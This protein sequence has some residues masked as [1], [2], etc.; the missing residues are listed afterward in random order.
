MYIYKYSLIKNKFFQIYKLKKHLYIIMGCAV[1]PLIKLGEAHILW[2]RE[3]CVCQTAKRRVC[4][5]RESKS[6]VL[7]LR[8]FS[9]VQRN[10]QWYRWGSPLDGPNASRFRLT[11]SSPSLLERS[12]GRF[13]REMFGCDR[14]SLH[15]VFSRNVRLFNL[16]CTVFVRS[17]EV[18]NLDLRDF[19]EGTAESPTISLGNFSENLLYWKLWCLF[20]YV[21]KNRKPN[22]VKFLAD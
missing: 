2:S 14:L 20:Y 7:D 18:V 4:R 17:S 6:F 3:M 9:C 21:H 11:C 1:W 13:S 16:V 22:V 5:V 10:P 8:V 12:T 19:F 15:G